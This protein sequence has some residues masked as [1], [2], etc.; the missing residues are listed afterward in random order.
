M[1]LPNLAA[2]AY[3]ASTISPVILEQNRAEGVLP[4][5]WRATIRFSLNDDRNSSVRNSIAGMLEQH[6]FHRRST[7]TWET[8]EEMPE[9]DVATVLHLLAEQLASAHRS[10]PDA[11][12]DHLWI[13]V[14]Q[15]TVD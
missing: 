15:L 7:G 4:M 6:R 12:L 14:D 9:A 8:D 11:H 2:V 13:Y 5:P 1:P 3:P 10:N